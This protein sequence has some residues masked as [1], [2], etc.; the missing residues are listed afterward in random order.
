MMLG[1]LVQH[2]F[3]VIRDWP[4][5]SAASIVLMLGV[6]LGAWFFMSRGARQGIAGEG[7][8]GTRGAAP[9]SRAPA[10]GRSAA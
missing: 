9:A 8:A 2:E 7:T 1:N 6:L 4:L 3:L 5:G 10:P